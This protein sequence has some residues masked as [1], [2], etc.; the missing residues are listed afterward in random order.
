LTERGT[1]DWEAPSGFALFHGPGIGDDA[2]VR[3]EVYTKQS[4]IILQYVVAV[5]AVAFAA[6]LHYRY[7]A[8]PF[9][10]GFVAIGVFNVGLARW[11]SVHPVLAATDEGLQLRKA[12]FSSTRKLAWNEV[13]TVEREARGWLLLQPRE[14]APLRIFAGSL[15]ATQ[16]DALIADVAKRRLSA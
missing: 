5:V 3:V 13:A 6:Y 10:L 14:G 2:P 12:V 16:L 7:A 4:S 1:G 15:D 11:S 9:V 8:T